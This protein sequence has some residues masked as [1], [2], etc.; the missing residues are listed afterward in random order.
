MS[1]PLVGAR[2][3]ARRSAEEPSSAA[4]AAPA[5]GAEQASDQFPAD[6]RC[7]IRPDAHHG[8]IA[9]APVLVLVLVF[10]GLCLGLAL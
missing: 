6:L 10:P 1:G 8:V 3:E 2:T 9:L 7:D 4:P 5:R